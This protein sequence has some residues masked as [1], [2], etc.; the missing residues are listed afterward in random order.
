MCQ[1][2]ELAELLAPMVC[3]FDELALLPPDVYVLGL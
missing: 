1:L 3:Q 2:D